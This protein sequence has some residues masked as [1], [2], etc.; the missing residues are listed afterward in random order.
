MKSSDWKFLLTGAAMVFSAGAA[1]ALRP[2]PTPEPVDLDLERIIPR[3]FGD[4]A[5]DPMIVPISPTPDVQT[6]LDR[7]YKQIVSRTYANSRGERVMLMIAYGG[8]QSDA[9]K[10]HR[11]E[12]CYAAQGFEIRNV[13]HE[14]LRFEGKTIPVTR[15]LAVRDARSEPVTYWFTMGDR[16]VFGRLERLLVQISYGLSGRIPDGMLVRVSSISTNPARAFTGHEEFVGALLGEMREGNVDR[17]L[18]SQGASQD[19]D[20]LAAGRRR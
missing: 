14:S 8:D 12:V 11:Q 15:L 7:L 9:L 19:Q 18:G 1:L 13:L 6:S 3:S 10:A 20:M 4:W 5:V 16:V 17:L 2:S